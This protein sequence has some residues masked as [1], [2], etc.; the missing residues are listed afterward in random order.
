MFPIFNEMI[1]FQSSV[2]WKRHRSGCISSDL[3]G[4]FFNGNDSAHIDKAKV[5]CRYLSSRTRVYL[6][7][8]EAFCCIP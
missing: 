2:E 3:S 7:S 1:Y 8:T 5:L 4:I 6:V